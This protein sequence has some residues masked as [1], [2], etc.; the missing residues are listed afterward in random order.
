MEDKIKIICPNCNRTD[1]YKK[2]P[3]YCAFC[4]TNLQNYLKNQSK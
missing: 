4:R 2:K 1:Y 3:N